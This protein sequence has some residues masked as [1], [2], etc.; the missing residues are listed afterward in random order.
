MKTLLSCSFLVGFLALAVGQANALLLTQANTFSA[1]NVDGINA[2]DTIGFTP[3]DTSLGTLNEV[4]VSIDDSMQLHVNNRLNFIP[5]SSV[6]PYSYT[7][8][9]LQ[10]FIG[11]G[12]PA[13][14][15]FHVFDTGQGL[16]QTYAESIAY[17]FVID[18]AAYLAFFLSANHINLVQGVSIE[19]SSATY[20]Y[21][22]NV[23][24]TGSIV[25]EYDYTPSPATAPDPVPEPSTAILLGA[26]L[27][28]IGFL[29]RKIKK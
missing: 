13:P 18:D 19:A 17:N 20:P 15:A 6:G 26:G 1:T 23:S 9:V 10:S 2:T 3:F 29:R 21:H 24:S 28:G 12:T 5:P 27:A 14:F 25:I 8:L 4:R 16:T 11:V 22:S 7:A